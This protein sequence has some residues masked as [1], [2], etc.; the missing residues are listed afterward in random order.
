MVKVTECKCD[1][2]DCGLEAEHE[3]I[4]L[5]VTFLTEQTEGTA[6]FPY[7]DFKQLDLCDM[8]YNEFLF[9]NPLTANGAQ[10]HN[11]YSLDVRLDRESWGKDVKA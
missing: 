7:I 8:H 5:P 9:N 6:R 11:N 2:L 10:G 4:S 1:I 3:G